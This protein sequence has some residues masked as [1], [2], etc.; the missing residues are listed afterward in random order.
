MAGLYIH[1]PFCHKA[2]VYCDFHFITSL[3]HKDAMLGAI[4]R[5]AAL[6]RTFFPEGQSLSTVYLGGGTP[7]I[8]GKEELAAL[9]AQ[10]HRHFDV[11][12]EAEITME[13]NPEDVSPAYFRSLREVGINRLSMGIQAF[14]DALLGWMNRGHTARRALESVVEARKAGFSNFSVD[15]IFG[16]PGL[17]LSQWEEALLRVQ[18]LEVPHLS[19]YALTVEARTALA[20][21]LAQGSTRL[22]E[23]EAFQEQFLR[24]HELLEQAGY[25]HYEISSYALPGFRSRHNSSYWNQQPYLGLGPS[26][27]SF[28]ESTRS[29]N[30]ANNAHY[31][32]ALAQGELPLAEAESLSSWDRYNEAIMTGL[33]QRA[34]VECAYIEQCFGVNLA[35][36]FG[37]LLETWRAAGYL[38]AG[39]EPES[40]RLAL[41]P[42]GWLVSDRLISELFLEEDSGSTSG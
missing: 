12:P 14:D 34:G 19:L 36:T 7:S 28:R 18:E 27:H 25:E 40:D 20:H 5:E 30:I 1:I 22:P 38:Q 13:V 2:C 35:R 31:I 9:F 8:L 4:H 3:K 41:S 15:L 26:A 33:R 32:K 16:L 23:D 37:N 17:G 39:W 24:A 10:V 42:A 21:Q 11:H 29:W 6:R